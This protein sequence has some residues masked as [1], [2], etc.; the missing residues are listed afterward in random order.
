MEDLWC[1]LIFQRPY[2]SIEYK[3]TDYNDFKKLIEVNKDFHRLVCEFYFENIQNSK[4]VAKNLSGGSKFNFI[5]KQKSIS[6][7][8]R[9]ISYKHKTTNIV[10]TRRLQSVITLGSLLEQ[11]IDFWNVELNKVKKD[12]KFDISDNKKIVIENFDFL[13]T[14][15][16]WQFNTPTI[17]NKK[18]QVNHTK[19]IFQKLFIDD[20][21]FRYKLALESLY[22]EVKIGLEITDKIIKVEDN[23]NDQND[24]IEKVVQYL[25]KILAKLPSIDF[26]YLKALKV[27]LNDKIKKFKTELDINDYNEQNQKKQ[28]EFA[29]HDF[30]YNQYKNDCNEILKAYIKPTNRQVAIL[31]YLL[32]ENEIIKIERKGLSRLNFSNILQE[33]EERKNIAGINKYF[34]PIWGN[35][36][37]RVNVNNDNDYL[38]IKNDIEKIFK[39]D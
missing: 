10:L 3:I 27:Y 26:D 16:D 2:I 4:N 28:S 32:I 7:Q 18:H 35:L 19:H 6:T 39:L 34:E 23:N 14:S 5:E 24:F 30:F 29:F 12:D 21:N 38:K 13:L 31:I 11:N 1:E 9:R 25:E 17:L 22:N 36:N 20:P 15:I 33:K 37:D 8:L